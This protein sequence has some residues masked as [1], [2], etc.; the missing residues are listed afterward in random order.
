[1]TR[2]RRVCR[3]WPALAVLPLLAAADSTARATTAFADATSAQG[4]VWHV[5]PTTDPVPGQYIVTLRSSDPGAVG[6][7]VSTL[8]KDHGGRVLAVYT[9]ALQGYAVETTA[10]AAEALANDPAVA[11]VEQN[12]YVRASDVT[13]P[14]S[15]T[16]SWASTASTSGR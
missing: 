16:P 8:T 14:E 1:M 9:D 4:G 3:H 5:Q 13:S 2:L 12:G 10:A 6:P 11:R 15:P 7:S